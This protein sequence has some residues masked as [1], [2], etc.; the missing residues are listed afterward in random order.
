ML[1]IRPHGAIDKGTAVEHLLAESD[2]RSALFGGD[3]SGDL[4][5]FAALRRLLKAGTLVAVVRIGVVSDEGPPELAERA[6]AVVQGTEGFLQV[7]RVLAESTPA[8]SG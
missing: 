1:E 8:P 2:A 7:L 4:A 5:A 3:D 6:D